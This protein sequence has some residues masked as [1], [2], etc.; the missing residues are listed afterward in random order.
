MLDRAVPKSGIH[1]GDGS[2]SLKN[3]EV[4]EIF[5]NFAVRYNQPK[6]MNKK[7]YFI[8]VDKVDSVLDLDN[9]DNETFKS[10]ADI[11]L[12]PEHFADRYNRQTE[13][14]AE[15]YYVRYI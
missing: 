6:N 4:S 14:D 13:P 8:A 2:I 11:V 12:T 3:L 15:C 1:G 10:M 7:F 5:T 9:V